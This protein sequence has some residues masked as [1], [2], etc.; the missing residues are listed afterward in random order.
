MKVGLVRQNEPY[1]ETV[2]FER[3]AQRANSLK[4]KLH[5]RISKRAPQPA[6]RCGLTPIFAWFSGAFRGHPLPSRAL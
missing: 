5:F 6:Y 3:A 4:I 1:A 2:H